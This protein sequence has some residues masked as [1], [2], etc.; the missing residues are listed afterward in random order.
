MT[1]RLLCVALVL[2][3]LLASLM[4]F[5]DW[6]ANPAG[7]FHGEQGTNWSVVGE[8]AWTWWWWRTTRCPSCPSTCASRPGMLAATAGSR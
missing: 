5:L 1:K 8:T 6:R 7:L 4:S 2:A 3:T